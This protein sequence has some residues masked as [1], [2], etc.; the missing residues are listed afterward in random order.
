MR[1]ETPL[2]GWFQGTVAE[3]GLEDPR[4]QDRRPRLPGDYSP[5]DPPRLPEKRLATGNRSQATFH[6][7]SARES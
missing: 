1:G 7:S 3:E 4:S 2:E 5:R 6:R